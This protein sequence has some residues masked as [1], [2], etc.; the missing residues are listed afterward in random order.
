[1]QQ[2]ERV[3]DASRRTLEKLSRMDKTELA[4]RLSERKLGPVG[5][6]LLETGSM[7]V[8]LRDQENPCTPENG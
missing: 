7:E 6:L 4:Q 8:I 5:Q 2:S 1:M 3:K